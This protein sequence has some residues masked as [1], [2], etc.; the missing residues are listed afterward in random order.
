MTVMTRRF[1]RLEPER[2]NIAAAD[3]TSRRTSA[4]DKTVLHG[5]YYYAPQRSSDDRQGGNEARLPSSAGDEWRRVLG[6][7]TAAAAAVRAF[8]GSL[9]DRTHSTVRRPW[10]AIAR[11]CA[12]RHDLRSG[13]GGRA[14]WWS[15]VAAA[16]GLC[17]ATTTIQQAMRVE[18]MCRRLCLSHAWCARFVL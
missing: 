15:T 2:H 6:A 17:G 10:Y 14:R 8:G 7:T 18:M 4:H 11:A 16:C 13:G 12:G 5:G 1:T 9:L 3:G